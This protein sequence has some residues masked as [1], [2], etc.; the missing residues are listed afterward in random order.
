MLNVDIIPR[1][2]TVNADDTIPYSYRSRVP[3]STVRRALM[4]LFAD[5]AGAAA[6]Y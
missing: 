1:I 3:Y 5:G 6:S 4:N 2:L